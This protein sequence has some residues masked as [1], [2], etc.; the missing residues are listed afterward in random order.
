MC[1]VTIETEGLYYSGYLGKPH[2]TPQEGYITVGTLERKGLP[3]TTPQEGYITVGTL[4][5]KGL[6]HTT[7]Q[8]GYIIVGTLERRGLLYTPHTT[9]QDKEDYPVPY[10]T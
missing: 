4:E 7:P 5:R 8:E 9:P 2:T 3:H 10:R 1:H 6:P